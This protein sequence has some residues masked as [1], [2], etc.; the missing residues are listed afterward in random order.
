MLVCDA[1]V[2]FNAAGWVIVALAVA[3]HPL[4][5]VT[6]QVHVP[7]LSPEAVAVVWAEPSFHK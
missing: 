1:G 6:V 2:R 5:S 4:L 3:V 7:A